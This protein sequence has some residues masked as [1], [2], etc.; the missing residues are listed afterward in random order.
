MTRL[1]DL[2]IDTGS[3]GTANEG[4]AV[5]AYMA[6]KSPALAHFADQLDKSAE[7]EE[8]ILD[9]AKKF[10]GKVLD[11]LGHGSDED[12][13]RDLQRKAGLPQTGFK[14]SEDPES[15]AGAHPARPNAKTEAATADIAFATFLFITFTSSVC[16]YLA[17][18]PLRFGFAQIQ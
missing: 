18:S 7:V 4:A 6:G 17:C 14:P 1:E 5:D 10:G 11:K 3:A 2:G 15:A 9:T 13:I 16:F 12:M 8:G